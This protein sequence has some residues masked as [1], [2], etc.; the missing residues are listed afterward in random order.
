MAMLAC[1]ES[2]FKNSAT[3]A[4]L[5]T[6]VRALRLDRNESAY[7]PSPTVTSAIRAVLGQ[8]QRFPEPGET[9]VNALAAFHRIKPQQIILGAGTSDLL[10]MAAATYLGSKPKLIMAAPTYPQIS[11]YARANHASVVEVPLRKDWSHDLEAML[12]VAGE[13]TGLVYVCNP[14]NPTGTL[15]ERALL[16]A[17]L[18]KLHPSVTVI[19][20]EAY[21]EYAGGS[22]A[23]R[24]FLGGFAARD[25]V[26]VTR[27][28]SKAYGL[29]G[30]RLGY[31]VSSE[32]TTRR[33]AL[34]RLDLGISEVAL[35]AGAAA[36]NDANHLAFSVRQN[37]NDRQEFVNQVNAR[38]LRVL[39][40][41]TNFA[42]LNVMQPAKKI[43]EHYQKNNILLGPEITSMPNYIRVSLGRT[44][45][46]KQFWQVWDLLGYHPMAM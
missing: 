43:L 13:G 33:L 11:V 3:P 41:H 20:D 42:C 45:E 19:I 12:G 36:L 31:A 34:Q 7:G 40:S 23:Y 15:T 22:G 2:S 6:S 32:A 30:L 24:S 39:D 26:I 25:N 38:M 35:L 18:D 17:F 28:F 9:L 27:T 44:D 8:I 29:A 16:E 14:N 21:H 37:Q 10:R 4:A 46:M 1:N 5:H